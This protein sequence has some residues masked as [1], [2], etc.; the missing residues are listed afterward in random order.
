MPLDA[1]TRNRIHLTSTDIPAHLIRCDRTYRLDGMAAGGTK[2]VA[3]FVMY[4]NGGRALL[5]F[6]ADVKPDGSFSSSINL[7]ELRKRAG[8]I[9]SDKETQSNAFSL[10]MTPVERDGTYWSSFSVP[11][12]VR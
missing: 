3:I 10:A 7:K 2:R 1:F 4:S 11:V 8:A 12:S 5:S 6:F 9:W